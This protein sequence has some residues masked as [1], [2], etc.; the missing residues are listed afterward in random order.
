MIEECVSVQWE[1]ADRVKS[2]DAFGDTCSYT[3]RIFTWAIISGSPT[4]AERRGAAL[5]TIEE[6]PSG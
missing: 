1:R 4:G 3:V 6:G 2:E 5:D